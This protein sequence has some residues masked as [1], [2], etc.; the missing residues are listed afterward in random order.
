MNAVLPLPVMAHASTSRPA[1]TEGDGIP[2][3]R[4]RGRV[5]ALGGDAAQGVGV[6]IERVERH[7]VSSLGQAWAQPVFRDVE[8]A[9]HRAEEEAGLRGLRRTRARN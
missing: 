5:E 3:D 1:S 4:R 2:L 7:G 9:S 8:V 6:K